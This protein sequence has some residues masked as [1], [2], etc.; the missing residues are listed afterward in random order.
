MKL[1]LHCVLATSTVAVLAFFVTSVR[2]TRAQTLTVL[3]SFKGHPDGAI[4]EAGLLMDKKGDL[5][6]TTSAGG[7]F[8]WGTVFKLDT[9]GH[10]TV[11]H[12]FPGSGSA[13]SIPV[14]GVVMDKTG[15]LYG[16]TEA[17]GTEAGEGGYGTVFKVDTAGDFST[18]H[19]FTGPP[20]GRY[21]TATLIID[22]RRDLYGTTVQGGSNDLGTVFKVDNLGNETVLYSFA[23]SDGAYPIGSHLIKD[24]E[25]NLYG[26]TWSGGSAGQGTVFK[27]DT[28]G[29][30]TTLHSFTGPDGSAPIGD[31]VM[32]KRGNLY[33]TTT[34][35]GSAGSGTVFK[36]DTAGNEVVLHSFSGS[37]SDGASPFQGVVMDK[38]GNLYGITLNGGSSG[39]GVVFKVG[40]SGKETVLHN[41]TNTPDG[42][43]PLGSLAVDSRGN[44]YG[45]TQNGGD[46]GLGTVFK[47]VPRAVRERRCHQHGEKREQDLSPDEHQHE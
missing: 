37:P 44:L 40:T 18:L 41:F 3:Y 7:D 28:E 26:T 33:G 43:S 16:T 6:G 8:D 36:L 19:R 39:S 14:A 25:G 21:P 4:A 42:S 47:L 31:L 45:T 1:L 22:R 13:G 17:G 34:G 5:Y 12:S 2:L 27:L 46:Y 15:N 29:K 9:A 35:G 38:D 10:E 23:G 11:L 32:D 30:L 20:D 24:K